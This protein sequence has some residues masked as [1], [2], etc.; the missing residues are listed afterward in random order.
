MEVNGIIYRFSR[1]MFRSLFRPEQIPFARG[2]VEKLFPGIYDRE[3]TL[4]RL[5][6]KYGD[7]HSE[8]ELIFFC[9]LARAGYAPIVE[10]GTF[11]GRTT[12]NLALNSECRI[13]T[14]DLGAE[15][16]RSVDANVNAEGQSYAEHTTGELFLNAPKVIRNRIDQVIGDST[17]VDLSHLYGKIGMVIVDGGHSYE[18]CKSD[19]EKALQL[20][21]KGGL[22]LWDDYTSYW[23]GVKKALDELS[24][25]VQLHYLPN[26]GV[27]VHIAGQ[28]TG[29]S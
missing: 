22:I 20:V 23:P 21:Q 15:I 7:L 10:F 14:I 1:R 16:G 26:E 24:R 19:S 17:K 11:R 6:P 3:I 29:R 27:V 18:V 8:K 25:S 4:G 5:T 2:E 9:A 28:D 13:T 12:Y